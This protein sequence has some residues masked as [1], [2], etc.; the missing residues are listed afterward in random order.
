ADT[1]Y[2]GPN[3]RTFVSQGIQSVLSTTTNTGPL[4]HRFETGI[5]FH[6]DSIDRRH[7]ETGFLMQGGQLV[8]S[9]EAELTTTNSFAS[10]HAV[11]LDLTDAMTWRDL[12]ITPGARVELISS[13]SNNRITKTI[14]D[15]LTPAVMPGVGAYYALL[16]YLG[17]LGGVYRGFSPP[18]P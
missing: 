2:I 13:R 10:T 11:A 14:T 18:P 1:L 3:D 6:Y 4:E 16:P 5:R 12:T 8:P 15:G 9:G 17:V 7:T